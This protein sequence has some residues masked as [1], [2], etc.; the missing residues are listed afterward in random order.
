LKGLTA[1][2]FI[3]KCWQNEKERFKINPH[4]YTLGLNIPAVVI[5]CKLADCCANGEI[6]AETLKANGLGVPL[7]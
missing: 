5:D 1:Y 3:I 2:E 4:H 7:S 6:N